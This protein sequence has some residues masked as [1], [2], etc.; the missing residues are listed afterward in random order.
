MVC[1]FHIAYVYCRC[2]GSPQQYPG[3]KEHIC[4][5]AL[6][7]GPGG[8]VKSDLWKYIITYSFSESFGEVGTCGW[9]MHKEILW[10]IVCM[11]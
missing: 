1:G 6:L 4:R 9:L 10:S 11:W 7:D 2:I 8:K 3:E 5:N